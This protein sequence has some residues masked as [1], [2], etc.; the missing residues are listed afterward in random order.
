MHNENFNTNHLVVLANRSMWH[1]GR[2]IVLI[3][4]N[5]LCYILAEV[6]VL[7]PIQPNEFLFP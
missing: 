4:W 7:I 5:I 1:N 6:M 3:R 2:N